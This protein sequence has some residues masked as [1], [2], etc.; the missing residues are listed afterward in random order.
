M[1]RWR[2]GMSNVR[3]RGAWAAAALLAAAPVLAGDGDVR[4]AVH[5]ALSME[6]PAVHTETHL[7]DLHEP[8]P[9]RP[10]EEIE[11]KRKDREGE[12]DQPDGDAPHHPEPHGPHRPRN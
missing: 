4:Q 8:E 7:P 1:M 11:N 2:R 3:L 9:G 6:L 10:G 5:D 12:R